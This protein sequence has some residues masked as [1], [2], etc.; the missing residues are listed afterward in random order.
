MIYNKK[1]TVIINDFIY[2]KMEYQNDQITQGSPNEQPIL[3][4]P[5]NSDQYYQI[6]SEGTNPNPPQIDYYQKPQ[7]DQYFPEN[8]NI[9]NQNNFILSP[10]NQLILLS[11]DQSSKYIKGNKFTIPYNRHILFFYVY[12]LVTSIVSILLLHSFHKIIAIVLFSI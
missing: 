3:Y 6:S 8:V 11:G 9:Q 4:Q 10:N 12:L 2:K 5:L 7:N 1:L